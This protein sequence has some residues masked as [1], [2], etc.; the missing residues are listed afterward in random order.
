M[1]RMFDKIDINEKISLIIRV[2]VETPND[3]NSRAESF[4]G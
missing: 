2:S 1:L 4:Q 3:E